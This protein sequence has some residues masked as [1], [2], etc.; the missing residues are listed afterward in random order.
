MSYQE[1][2][3]SKLQEKKIE[4]IRQMKNPFEDDLLQR[5]ELAETLAQIIKNTK[6]PYVYNINSPYGTGKT[7]FLKRL[8]VLLEQQGCVSVL[9]NSWETDYMHNPLVP[10]IEEINTEVQVAQTG[11]LSS[12]AAACKKTWGQALSA[13][14]ALL[15]VVPGVGTALKVTDRAL[16][17]KEKNNKKIA[18]LEQYIELK[19]CKAKFKEKLAKAAGCL[20]APLVII[21]D[22]LDRCRPNYAV[23]TLETIKHFFDIPNV[24][25]VL[26][27]DRKQIE[28]AVSVLYGS[29]IEENCTEYL[30]KFIDYDFYLPEPESKDYIAMLVKIHLEGFFSK[31][32]SGGDDHIFSLID[33]TDN[34]IKNVE[35]L[36]QYMTVLI[37]AVCLYFRFSFRAQEQFVIRLRVFLAALNPEKDIFIPELTILLNGLKFT[38]HAFFKEFKASKDIQKYFLVRLRQDK[39]NKAAWSSFE[40]YAFD[41]QLNVHILSDL[42][43][44]IKK[45]QPSNVDNAILSWSNAILQRGRVSL[46]GP[47]GYGVPTEIS[48]NIFAMGKLYIQLVSSF[49][50]PEKEVKENNSSH[51]GFMVL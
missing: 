43:R 27:M 19:E 45:F 25:F 33:W 40:K 38:S 23:E 10:L 24:V 16:E 39:A 2:T 47:N 7:F 34:S 51:L 17:I 28:S 4:D 26:A 49:N 1:S 5:K 20:P 44:T 3:F 13:G 15:E 14:K 36:C 42:D 12:L 46:I 41:K 31:F 48:D 50:T 8:K 9:Y 6:S 35:K 21:V 37:Q 32:L 30:R 29:G 22:E 11:Y 18:P